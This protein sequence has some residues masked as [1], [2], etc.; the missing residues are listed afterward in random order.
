[1]SRPTRALARGGITA[2]ELKAAAPGSY[3]RHEE[4]VRA[5]LEY[6]ALCDVPAVAIYTGPKIARGPDGG[7]LLRKNRAQAGFGDVLAVLP[8]HGRTFVVDAKTGPRSALQPN[9]R[10][11]HDHLRTAGALT[12]TI[13]DVRELEQYVRPRGVRFQGEGL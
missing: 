4:L 8:P 5:I 7:V 3:R 1:V 11:L 13:R 10:A 2:R 6:F 12:A 9:Q